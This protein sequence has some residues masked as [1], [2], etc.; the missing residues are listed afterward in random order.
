MARAA[1][2]SFPNQLRRNKS[3]IATLSDSISAR[4]GSGPTPRPKETGGSEEIRRH[5]LSLSRVSLF[6]RLVQDQLEKVAEQMRLVNVP[7][8]MDVQRQGD[9]CT[10]LVVVLSGRCVEL[11]D[12]VAVQG[13]Q[14]GA[15]S[16]FGAQAL[17]YSKVALSAATTTVRTVTNCTML[18]LDRK[19]FDE[20]VKQDA[21]LGAELTKLREQIAAA[22][23]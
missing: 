6:G 23:A 17:L 7:A 8:G 1:P 10:H 11:L 19:T 12:G 22:I 16:V 21:K 20:L 9:P 4:R 13:H 3:V 5:S 15:N 14:L 2:F 18:T